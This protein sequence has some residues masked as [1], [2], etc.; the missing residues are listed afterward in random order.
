MVAQLFR[1]QTPTTGTASS[2]PGQ[3]GKIPSAVQPKYKINALKK[4]K[5]LYE[6]KC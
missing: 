3:T 4:K 6:V 1:P 2:T 5:K